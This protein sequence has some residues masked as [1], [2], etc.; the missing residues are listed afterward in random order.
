M[1][2]ERSFQELTERLHHL[3]ESLLALRTITI[4][5]KPID[6]DAVLVDLFGDAIDDMLGWTE[7]AW[8]SSGEARQAVQHPT[9]LNRL[10]RALSDCQ[11]R[12]THVQQ[13]YADD[14]SSFDRLTELNDLAERR[15]G[16]W[17][18]WASTLKASLEDCREPLYEVV[19]SIFVCWQE[20][21][22]R[23]GIHSIHVQTTNIG[24]YLTLANKRG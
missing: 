6:D 9:D 16:E 20:M 10:W 13:R 19:D 18:A 4:E 8:R 21:G 23:M 14:L 11:Q 12:F 5:D 1:A 24:Q 22:E 3:S 7:G 15:G 17:Q 2:L